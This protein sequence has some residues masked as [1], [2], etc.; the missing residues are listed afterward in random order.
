MLIDLLRRVGTDAPDRAVVISPQGQTSYAECLERA[1]AIAAG[2][3]EREIDRFALLAS[4]PAEVVAALAAAT[5]IGAEPCVYPQELD[6]A[7]LAK[8]STDFDHE[9]LVA[10]RW[11][12]AGLASPASA[13]VL[14]LDELAGGGEA[15]AAQPGA[16]ILILTTGTTGDQKGVRHTWERLARAVRKPDDRPG[17]RWLL[18]YNLNQFA[19]IQILLHVLISGSTMVAPPSRRPRDL[20][21]TIREHE[22]T[23][24]S[25]TP[26]LW[27]LLIGSLDDRTAADL[28]LEQITLGGEA[29]D[30]QLLGRLRELFGDA[31]ITHVY[32]GSEFGSAI[33]VGDGRAGLPLSVLERGEDSPVQVRIEDGELQLRSRAGMLGYFE[34]A[35]TEDEWV[36]TGDMVEVHGDRIHF[37][38]RRSE[39]INVGGA[40]VHPL[41]IEELVCGIEGVEIAAAYGRPNPVTGQIVALDVVA[42]AGADPSELEAAIRAACEALPR[43]GRPRRIR[44]VPELEIRGNKLIR[45]EVKVQAGA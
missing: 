12:V 45:D 2:L 16:P 37:V 39:I 15:A 34:G 35:D 17:T 28:P 40:K 11:P 38:G 1:E 9:V 20:I 43:P 32:A 36:A 31:R 24:L 21:E 10:D 27:R 42:A 23:H 33:A 3:A 5:A 30:D 13:D 4:D 14:N 6:D 8:L 29:S 44:F 41:P 7:R 19:G 25:A 26:T 22:V 18:A